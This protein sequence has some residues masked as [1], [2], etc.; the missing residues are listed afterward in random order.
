MLL[1]RVVSIRYRTG[2]SPILG[3]PLVRTGRTLHQVPLIAE[4]GVQVAVV[5]LHRVGG[6]CAFQPAADRVDTFAAAIGVFPAEALF[7][8][9]GP[10]PFGAA[11][12]PRLSPPHAS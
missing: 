11:L 12:L 2:S 8:P 4:Q 3:R 7:L 6:P 5:P 1:R 9:F 10:L